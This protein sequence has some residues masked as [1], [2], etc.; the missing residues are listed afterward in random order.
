M[1][2]LSYLK[3][4]FTEDAKNKVIKYQDKIHHLEA[5]AAAKKYDLDF[6]KTCMFRHELS[7]ISGVRQGA[8][9]IVK[10]PMESG[11]TGLYKV[12]SEMFNYGGTGQRDWYFEFQGYAE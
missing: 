11:K 9:E 7:H 2:I 4:C 1:N 6:V 3:K 12:T 5:R 8:G 10:I